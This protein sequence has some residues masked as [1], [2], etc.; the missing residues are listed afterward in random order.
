MNS[1]MVETKA[2]RY[3]EF[4]WKQH[5]CGCCLNTHHRIVLIQQFDIDKRFRYSTGG[6]FLLFGFLFGGLSLW[7][8]FAWWQ[9]ENLHSINL[10][11][12]KINRSLWNQK[13]LNLVNLFEANWNHFK[14]CQ[15]TDSIIEWWAT[16]S[17]QMFDYC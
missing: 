8:I 5:T 4:C 3:V 9:K 10:N 13:A 15:L 17:I 1:W 7:Q 11:M 12:V 6:V 2:N 14:K 16:V